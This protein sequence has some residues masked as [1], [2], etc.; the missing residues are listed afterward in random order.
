M[1]L[2]AFMTILRRRAWVI[3]IVT[4]LALALAGLSIVRSTPVYEAKATIYIATTIDGQY[5]SGQTNYADRLKRTYSI[6]TTSDPFLDE[7]QVRFGLPQ[8]PDVDV[9]VLANT[10]LMEVKARDLDPDLAA[11]ISNAIAESIVD[12]SARTLQGQANPVSV[13]QPAGV[14][15]SPAGPNNTLTLA[16]GTIAGLMGG[17][18]LALLMENLDTTLHSTEHVRD[19]TGLLV[20]GEI[21]KLPRNF[22]ITAVAEDRGAGQESFHTL[23]SNLV[24][25]SAERRLRSI[26]VTAALPGEGKSTVA[27][28]LSQVMAKSARKVVI[29]DA[30]LRMPSVHE[31]LDVSNSEGLRDVL[32]TGKP[33]GEVIQD[34]PESPGLSVITSGSPTAQPFELFAAERMMLMLIELESLF[35]AIII[36]TPPLARVPDAALIAP[37]TDGVLLVIGQGRANLGAVTAAEQ[38][39]AI[40]RTEPI[41]VV[42]NRAKRRWPSPKYYA[43]TS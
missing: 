13:R 26:T 5:N 20:L 28:G 35:D 18:A 36:D 16:L 37:Q 43:S 21:P 3:V 9:V 14:P 23:Q 17:L 4:A 10:E 32:A 6:L 40:A 2:R 8:Q 33:V 22:D 39:L 19:A 25:L 27:V 1:Q 41:G 42:I 38:Q 34:V 24:G 31:L 7:L 29:I 11:A 12:E 30:D 15:Q